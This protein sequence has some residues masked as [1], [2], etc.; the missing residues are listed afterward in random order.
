MTNEWDADRIDETR[1]TLADL[2]E[3]MWSDLRMMADPGSKRI[4][5]QLLAGAEDA[6]SKIL[7]TLRA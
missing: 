6:K 1:E 5:E 3:T 4:R 7:A 2:I